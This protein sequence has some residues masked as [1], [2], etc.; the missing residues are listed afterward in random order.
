MSGP[1]NKNNRKVI[2]EVKGISKHFGG[3]KAVDNV[4]LKLYKGE[5][6]AIVGDNGAGKSTL[7][8]M[9]SGVYK[10]DRGEI[11]INGKEAKI[12]NTIDAR[13][14]GI[15]TVYQ[16]QGLVQNFNASLNLF[17]GREIMT[18][19]GTL[20]E[21]AMEKEA[22]QVISRLNPNFKNITDAVKNM[23]G[24]Q[25]QS[26]AIARAIYFNAK[27]LI[28]DEPTSAI[29]E[30][31]IDILF[32]IIGKLKRQGVAGQ[33]LGDF[34]DLLLTDPQ[35]AKRC[36]RI[37]G[38]IEFF[39]Q[40]GRFAVHCCRVDESHWIHGFAAEKDILGDGQV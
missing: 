9:I 3:I 35:G 23:S 27:I 2:L 40:G 38:K 32:G 28:M 29:T 30:H 6:I 8:K 7:I 4:D 31:E 37:H 21:F 19:Y 34:H 16:D 13:N 10:K 33:R 26:V 24:G 20:D 25:R 36:R 18:K 15:E 14:Y 39:E 12:E 22:R 11:Y 1:S 17:L 5:I